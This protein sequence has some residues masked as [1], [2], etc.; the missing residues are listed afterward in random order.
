VRIALDH[1]KGPLDATVTVLRSGKWVGTEL[2]AAYTAWCPGRTD[3]VLTPK[4]FSIQ[5]ETHD[6]GLIRKL[7]INGNAWWKGVA[8]S[9]IAPPED[10]EDLI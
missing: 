1:D 2:H 4:D 8:L 3:I 10:I 9:L 5:L 7:K 6:P